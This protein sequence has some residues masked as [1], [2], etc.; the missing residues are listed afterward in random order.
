[1]EGACKP[2]DERR[3]DKFKDNLGLTLF[4]SIILKVNLVDS[5]VTR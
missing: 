4:Y 1:M 5:P 3:S 2:A